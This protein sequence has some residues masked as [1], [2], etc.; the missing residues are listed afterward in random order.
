[1]RE[2]KFLD[3]VHGYIS[4]PENYCH[5]L[6]DTKNFQRLR[7]IEQTS[8][9]SLFPCARH[10]RFVHSLGVFHLG[11]KFIVSIS[12][13]LPIS[14][15]LKESFQI[16]CLLHDC[17]HS[18]FS[19]TLEHLFGTPDE[20]FEKYVAS[21]KQRDVDSEIL[22]VQI[23]DYDTKPHEIL[24]AWLCIT[25][26]YDAI[27][28]LNAD[29]ALVGRMIM[30]VPYNTIE[31]S[32]DDCFIALLHGG[33][34]DVD[35]LDYICRD[36]WASGYLSDSIDLDRLIG[37]AEIHCD[38]KGKYKVAFSKSC[39][40]EIQSLMD[41][42]NFQ[43]NS[44][45][46]HH[47]VVYEQKLL[48]NIVKKLISRL[49]LDGKMPSN[50]LFN[51][52]AFNEKQRVS[53]NTEIYLPADDDIVH[54]LKIHHESISGVDEWLSRNYNFF[55][56][57]KSY[58][59]L[60]AI[61]GKENAKKLLEGSGKVYD[62]LSCKI[63]K[64]FSAN[65]LFLEATPVMKEVSPGDI[66]IKFDNDRYVDYCELELPRGNNIYKNQIFKY[67]FIETRLKSRRDEILSLINHFLDSY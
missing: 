11:K 65:P 4:V 21:L 59:E 42:K 23:S 33:L 12:R 30:G 62:D 53:G 57:W 46:K 18:P 32:L 29:P 45:F 34:I 36:K 56:L 15:T 25:V 22:E 50:R 9:R 14:D 37:G 66:E 10:D 41:S 60:K 19:H 5:K 20:L 7:R 55:P 48:Q 2:K 31:K 64:V 16:A 13:C 28:E 6:I 26:Y 49:Q 67:L 63:R 47:Q 8:A 58:S 39:I 51:L 17:G 61:L 44:V 43:T 1:M 54:L 24:S 40:N 27:K 52:D 38:E 35:K 3:T